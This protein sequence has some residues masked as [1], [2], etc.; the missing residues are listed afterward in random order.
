MRLLVD[1]DAFCKLAV[2]G[3]FEDALHALQ[4]EPA[5][6]ARLA[7][8]PPMLERGRLRKRLGD[9]ACDALIPTARSIPVIPPGASEWVD[10]L[11]LIVDIDA[12]E[13]QIFA[14][15]AELDLLV[16]SGDKRALQALKNAP[17]V[18]ERLC[19][20]VVVLEALLI[21]VAERLGVDEL[22]RR[23]VPVYSLDKAV[24][25]CFSANENE[26]L[27]ALRSYYDA[28]KREVSPLV[29]WDPGPDGEP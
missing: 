2:G 3:L 14:V 22:R 17:E 25:V 18:C 11:T 12:G 29:L 1:S 15:A 24:R 21:R 4:L 8:L 28:L 19:G 9:E 26:P 27:G 6:C 10:Q 16:I 23:L 5:D 13:A 20:N 7:A